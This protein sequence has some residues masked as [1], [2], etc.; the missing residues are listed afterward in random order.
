[1]EDA[2]SDVATSMDAVAPVDAGDAGATTDVGASDTGVSDTGYV[3]PDVGPPDTGPADAGPPTFSNLYA[4]IFPAN[5]C[6]THHAG[7][8][9]YGGLDMTTQAIA[10]TNL[11]GAKSA[12]PSGES[13]ACP[14]ERVVPG[15]ASMSLL[16]LKV[17]EAKPPCGLQMPLDQPPL[18]ATELTLIMDWINDGAKNN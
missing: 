1:M 16:Y 13:P 14:G 9:E 5:G 11:V 10:Y 12:T 4:T 15:S 7:G 8:N 6:T 2:G 17:S 3:M 18:T